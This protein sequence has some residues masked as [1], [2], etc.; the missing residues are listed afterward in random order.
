MCIGQWERG[1][2][3]ESQ[4]W[5]SSLQQTWVT[6]MSLLY[7]SLSASRGEGEDWG[8]MEFPADGQGTRCRCGL[9][10]PGWVP[11]SEEKKGRD[12]EHQWVE[13]MWTHTYGRMCVFGEGRP[14][15]SFRKEAKK[16]RP[17]K[18]PDGLL[19]ICFY[20]VRTSKWR[21][22]LTG[23]LKHIWVLRLLQHQRAAWTC[24]SQGRA[25]QSAIFDQPL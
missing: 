25:F 13:A 22:V 8:C 1:V 12:W 4:D 24:H 19:C 18:V 3:P 10:E 7:S 14:M 15:R 2:Q 17:L 16:R 11:W 20:Q 21:K 6:C 5:C 23:R 9:W